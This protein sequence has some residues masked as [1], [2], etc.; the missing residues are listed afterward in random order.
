MTICLFMTLQKNWPLIQGVTLAVPED[1]WHRGS[2]TLGT[3]RA[4]GAVIE[5]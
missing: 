1:R 4:G 5:K 3:L 2:T